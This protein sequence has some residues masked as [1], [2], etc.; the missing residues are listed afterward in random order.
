[1]NEKNP[2]RL[3]F[4]STMENIQF[5][6]TLHSNCHLIKTFAMKSI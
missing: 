5:L 2:N 4:F 1:M 6:Q 3:L